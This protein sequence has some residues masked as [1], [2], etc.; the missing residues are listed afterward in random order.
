MAKGQVS[1]FAS[2]CENILADHEEIITMQE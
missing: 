2:L 1:T